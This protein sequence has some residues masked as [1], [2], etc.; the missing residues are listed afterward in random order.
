[1]IL[2]LVSVGKLLEGRARR[3][4]AGAVRALIAEEPRT[5][6]VIS[7]DGEKDIL[8]EEITLG[9]CV[10]VLEGEKIPL[11]GVIFSGEGSVNA[12]L[13]T[14]LEAQHLRS[15]RTSIRTVPS[16]FWPFHCCGS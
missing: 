9:A 16:R 4:A 13:P 7:A 3:R 6:R 5:A 10:K 8:L 14:E 1:M 15:E 2:T 12:V 11:D